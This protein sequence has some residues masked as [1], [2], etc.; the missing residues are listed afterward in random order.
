MEINICLRLFR[1]F[2]EFGPEIIKEYFLLDDLNLKSYIK[3]VLQIIIFFSGWPP[4]GVD[5][6]SCI[7]SFL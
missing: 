3:K 5:S 6:L 1:I 4:G 7:L 2:L